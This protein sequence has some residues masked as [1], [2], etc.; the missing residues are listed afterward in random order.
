MEPQPVPPVYAPEVA[1][2]A[3]LHCAQ[4]PAR[5]V[6]IGGLGKVISWSRGAPRLADRYM[7]RS[8][9][10]AQ[11]TDQPALERLDNLY[12]PVGN[13][14]GERGSNWTGRTKRTSVYTMAAL[15]PRIGR[16]AAAGAGALLGTWLLHR[17]GADD[18][19]E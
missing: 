11:K 10:D 18:S 19:A 6:I 12:G 13:D 7:E 17:R 4:H 8:T 15:H 14:G 2:R 3:I 9:F 5:D 1:A 16:V